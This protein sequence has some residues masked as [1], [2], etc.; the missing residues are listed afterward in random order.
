MIPVV[1]AGEASQ[2][3]Q[4]ARDPVD[5]LMD[6][7]GL[8]IALRA[9]ELGAG[10]GTR[11][12][13][14]CGP[15]NNGG[16][17]Y[18]AGRYLRQR[19]VAVQVAALAEPRT[20]AAIAAAEAAR[21]AGLRIG[22][23]GRPGG[24]ELVIDALFGGGFRR[25]L[26]PAVGPWIDAAVPVV[27]VDVPSGL[28]PDTGKAPDGALHATATVTFG[29][30][31]PA[32]LIGDG[33][34][35]CG[36]VSV[37]D[38]G[39]GEGEPIMRVVEDE[40]AFRPPRPPDVHKWSAGSVLVVGGSPGMVGAAVMAGRSALHFGAGAVGVVSPQPD[41]VAALAPELLSF[42]LGRLTEMLDR[43]DVAVVGPGLGDLPEVV[44][45]VLG[46]AQC[47]VVDADGLRDDGV[48]VSAAA[49]LVVTPHSGEF[50]RLSEQPPGPEAARSLAKAIGGV[51]LLKGWPTFITDGSV[52][53]AVVSGGSELATIG[54]GDVLAGM[55]AAL[56]ARGLSPLEAAVSA[57]HWHG[58]AASDLAAITTVTA[59]RLATHVGHWSGV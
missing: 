34:E 44:D 11:V 17:G 45:Q 48:L 59:D 19:G 24:E 35:L 55:T 43:Y 46:E 26:P 49:D 5:V 38:I 15:G 13:I 56:W 9:V 36:S 57:S 2:M 53:W 6:R 40:D 50:A 42:P 51:V 3:D 47:A 8:A 21:R 32:H 7:A 39:L 23:L 30:L 33:P 31:K 27:S 52:P 28:H 18:V 25:G 41:L 1:T 37:V 16:D 58:V 14:L 54:T 10:Y 4:R 29:A 12:T 22:P 20:P